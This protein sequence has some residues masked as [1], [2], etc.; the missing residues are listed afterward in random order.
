MQWCFPTQKQRVHA[1]DEHNQEMKCWYKSELRRANL[2]VPSVLPHQ[3]P[4]VGCLVPAVRVVLGTDEL[5]GCRDEAEGET[6]WILPGAG[7]F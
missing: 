2:A 3:Q 1:W 4:D 5:G 6:G 7:Q